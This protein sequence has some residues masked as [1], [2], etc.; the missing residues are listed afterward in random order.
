[1]AR[2]EGFEL[3]QVGFDELVAEA[4]RSAAMK[5]HLLALAQEVVAV[6]E[7]DAEPLG[8]RHGSEDRGGPSYK[9]AFGTAIVPYG[10]VYAAVAYN[11]AYDAVWNELGSHPHGG[12]TP[13]QGYHILG[14]AL[15]K[16]FGA[17][18][19]RKVQKG[20]NSNRKGRRR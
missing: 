18:A 10:K 16:V 19:I 20:L 6:A 17:D 8:H 9:D 15:E 14:R 3:S 13:A 12:P 1:M 7:A 4:G 2:D 5:E 11:S